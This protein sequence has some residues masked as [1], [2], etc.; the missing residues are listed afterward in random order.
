[1]SVFSFIPLFLVWSGLGVALRF[2]T[3]GTFRFNPEE[4]ESVALGATRQAEGFFR[5]MNFKMVERGECCTVWVMYNT[6]NHKP[7]RPIYICPVC[8]ASPIGPGP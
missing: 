7:K 6:A 3:V 8:M 5:I 1:L 2:H 4:G